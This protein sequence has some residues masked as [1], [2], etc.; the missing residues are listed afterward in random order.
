MLFSSSP[1]LSNR[2]KSLPVV[3]SRTGR[4]RMHSTPMMFICHAFLAIRAAC[5]ALST[6]LVLPINAAAM[7]C[8]K[9][10]GT[11]I[12]GEK[13]AVIIPGKAQNASSFVPI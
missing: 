5:A 7:A 4:M 10:H 13:A 8:V 3:S 1:L 2:Q 6:A 9:V 12:S 11:P